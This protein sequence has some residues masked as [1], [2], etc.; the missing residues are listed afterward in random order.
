MTKTK[1][2]S[3]RSHYKSTLVL[4]FPLIRSHIMQIVPHLTDTSMLGWY[5]VDE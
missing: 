1:E 2:H 3:Y 4:G 5:G